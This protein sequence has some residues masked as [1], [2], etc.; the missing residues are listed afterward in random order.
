MRRPVLFGNWKMYKTIPEALAL[1][2]G[3]IGGLPASPSADIG[4]APPF[5]ALAMVAAK[6]RG[7]PLLLA[8]QNLHQEEEGAFTGEVSAGMLAD[9]G[10]SHV[11]VG[12]S[13]RRQLF[14]ET[15][16]SV[17][18][19]VGSAFRHGLTPIVCVGEDRAER[20]GGETL[21]KVERQVKAALD[22]IPLSDAERMV[23]AYEPIWAIGTG[24]TATPEQAQEVH[25][26]IRRVVAAAASPEV[27]RA[28]RIIYGG[29]VKPDNFAA[30]LMGSDIDGALVGG[31]SLKAEGFLLLVAALTA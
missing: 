9:L 24:L 1:V 18:L 14:G 26:H 25:A 17:R 11:L 12:H 31:A 22:G 3:I 23:I 19:K 7:T 30:I 20:E 15:D 13:E 16:A 2:E 10:C 29:S 5:T 6:L 4:V 27:A 21:A 8:G 28:V